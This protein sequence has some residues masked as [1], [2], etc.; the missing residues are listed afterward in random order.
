MGLLQQ[1]LGL[2]GVAGGNPQGLIEIPDS[3]NPRYGTNMG[4][5]VN[6]PMVYTNQTT[7]PVPQDS[8]PAPSQPASPTMEAPRKKRG[9]LNS[10]GHI[11]GDVFMP[12][13]DSLYA[14]A[15]R[16][17]IWNARE[18]RENYRY[19]SNAK[20]LEARTNAYKFQQLT[21]NGEYKVVGNNVF[22]IKPDGTYDVISAPTTSDKERMF[23]QWQAMPE[24]PDKEMLS[25]VLLGANSDTAF[26]SRET[27]A[28]I[29]ANAT[30]RAAGIRAANKPSTPAIP[31]GWG[32]VK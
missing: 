13:P 4:G 24:G 32:V 9:L 12:N 30:T 6:G 17:G 14:G 5:D 29:R 16:D 31:Q 22:H 26:G 7:E 28:R 2:A 21:Q 20:E 1:I 15:L 23:Q 11:L 25:R 3:Y 19:A 27:I 8:S 18:S 10:I